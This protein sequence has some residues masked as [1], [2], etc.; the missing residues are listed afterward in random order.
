LKD[1]DIQRLAWKHGQRPGDPAVVIDPAVVPVPGILPQVTSVTSMPAL[2]VMNRILAAIAPPPPSGTPNSTFAPLVPIGP[3]T[4]IGRA[5]LAAS[6]RQRRS[7]ERRHMMF[8]M[9]TCRTAACRP[10][11]HL[12]LLL[13][14]L[15]VMLGMLGP[16]ATVAQGT[17]DVSI[18]VSVGW[19]AP[20]EERTDIRT[21]PEATHETVLVHEV[22]IVIVA[23]GDFAP[24]PARLAALEELGPDP[25]TLV[26]VDAGTEGDPQYWLDLVTVE[27]TPYGAFTLARGVESGVALTMFLGPVATFADGMAQSQEVVLVDGEPLFEGVDPVGL[28]TLLEAW[29]PQLDAGGAADVGAPDDAEASETAGGTRSHRLTNRA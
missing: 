26:S 7:P 9:H 4:F 10:H 24:A 28:Q 23:N 27:G 3:L 12:H 19:S 13:L 14:L 1:H 25:D 2:E 22:D 21:V 29:L 15:L 17:G 16:G 5:T 20:F 6:G 11:L 18:D 8:A